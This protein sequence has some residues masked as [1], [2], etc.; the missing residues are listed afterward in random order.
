[1]K[2]QFNQIIKS[3]D[4][5]EITI[6]LVDKVL[7]NNIGDEII[8][9]IPILKFLVSA[10][11]IYSSY[12]DRIF[13]KKAMY[14]LLELGDT[15]WK[16]RIELTIDLDDENSTGAEKILMSIDNLETLEKCKVFGRL[17]KL[18]ALRQIDLYEFK[19]LTKLIQ[20]AY[21]DDLDLL[22]LLSGRIEK[23]KEKKN[24]IHERNNIYIEEFYPLI[25]LGL[26]YQEQGEQTPIEKVE[27]TSYKDG[28]A[29]YT[30]G[31]IEM[32]FFISDLGKLLLSFYNDLFSEKK[33]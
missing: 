20:D 29:Y 17:C 32:L 10:R 27:P 11:N 22:P 15:N 19:R 33:D 7:E 8:K 3:E 5:K 28:P 18:K 26:I 23:N 13:I 14:V 6:E 1:M 12:T 31:E 2:E 24:F 16:E 21:L 4:L 25:G 9:E 30:G